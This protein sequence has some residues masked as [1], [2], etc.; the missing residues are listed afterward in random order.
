VPSTPAAADAGEPANP[1][2]LGLA[3]LLI[4]VGVLSTAVANRQ[5]AGA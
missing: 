5:G 3:V 1:L 4:T 2:L